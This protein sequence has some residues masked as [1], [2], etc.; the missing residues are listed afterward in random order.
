MTMVPVNVRP[1]DEPLPPELGNRFALVFFGFPS[2]TFAPLAR[3]AETKR[4]MDWL[5]QSPEAA[6]TLG[7]INVL[8]LTTT[9]L[10]RRLVDYFANK[11]IGVTTNVAGPAQQRY[12]AGVAMTGAL[13]WVRVGQPHRGSVHLHVWDRPGR[14]HAGRRSRP[15]PGVT[16][17][18]LRAGGARLSTSI[19]TIGALNGAAG[20]RGPRGGG[21]VG[22]PGGLRPEAA[23][24]RIYS[25]MVVDQFTEAEVDR[26]FHA[27]ADRTRRDIVRRVL[28]AEPRSQHSPA[29]T[30]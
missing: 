7:I 11:A 30:R 2:A 19:G 10:E 9:G 29:T 16:A 20:R 23:G 1:L 8:G 3:L 28:V 14:L 27:L 6:L 26:L 17:G 22:E 21:L 13:G 25:L 5:K 4:R 12:L 15:R 24:C 18:R